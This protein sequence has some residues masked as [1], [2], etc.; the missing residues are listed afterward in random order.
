MT[1]GS[2]EGRLQPKR[3]RCRFLRS[4]P[5][6]LSLMT[7]SLDLFRRSPNPTRIHV[8]G[9]STSTHC[10]LR[11]CPSGIRVRELTSKSRNLF[12]AGLREAPKQV[13]LL[14][15]ACADVRKPDLVRE[16]AIDDGLKNLVRLLQHIFTREQ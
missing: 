3:P 15:R 11:P 12:L 5:F 10:R 14:H 9:A 4:C 16:I 13:E 8:T 6:C 7:D 2:T 1:V